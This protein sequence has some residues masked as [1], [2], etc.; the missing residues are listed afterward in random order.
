M[1]EEEELGD[2]VLEVEFRRERVEEGGVEEDRREERG[3]GGVE[4]ERNLDINFME[5]TY[6]MVGAEMR[7][8][9]VRRTGT[10]EDRISTMISGVRA[11][12]KTRLSSGRVTHL[13]SAPARSLVLIVTVV[14]HGDDG[15]YEESGGESGVGVGGCS[16]M[17]WGR[18]I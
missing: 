10:V 6:K 14:G 8:R 18:F 11:D 2:E 9:G 16:W 15:E 4:D 12:H 13:L 1:E 7:V 5:E 17:M 3:V